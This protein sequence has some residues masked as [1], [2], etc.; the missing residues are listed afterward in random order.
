MSRAKPTIQVIVDETIHEKRWISVL[1][2]A[3]GAAAA[4]IDRPVAPIRVI[5]VLAHGRGR[6]ALGGDR[7]T[8]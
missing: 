1:L 3:H 2:A 7:G 8:G 5:F 6:L 4:Y